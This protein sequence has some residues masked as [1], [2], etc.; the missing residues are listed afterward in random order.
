MNASIRGIEY[1]LPEQA[2]SNRDLA[3]EFPE[4]TIG[5]IQGKTGI[6]ERHVAAPNETAADLAAQAARKL[7]D[8]GACSTNEI[9][10][11]LLCTQTP[12]HFLPTTACLLQHRLGIPT[13]AGALDFNLGC[14]GFVYG[15]G[16]AQ[17]LIETE[18]ATCI[19]LLTAETYTKLIHPRDRS[20]RTLFGDAAAA[21]LITATPAPERRRSS[22]T[23][24]TDGSGGPNL[25]VPAGGMR[26][27][28]S[29][30][31]AQAVEDDT[32]N[33][34]SP[35][36]LYMDGAEIF[37]FT[38][39]AIPECV[40][41]VLARG[42]KQLDDIDLFV[43]HQANQYMLDHLRK[44]LGIPAAKFYVHLENCGNTISSTIPIALKHA[45]GAKRL[46]A[47]QTV[48]LVGFGVGYSWA[49]TILEWPLLGLSET[50][51]AK[52]KVPEL[53]ATSSERS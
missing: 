37:N 18:Q 34:R 6:L 49:A 41:R 19:L 10:F 53:T 12:D 52:E 51:G 39:S 30:E 27:R 38:L 14:S 45:L 36:N 24:G 47:G 11:L 44:K 1:H 16:L 3:A 29:A 48:M 31:T 15:L 21:T 42:R 26:R 25:I 13:H 33:W 8:S 40:N 28:S 46:E 7:F 35:D 20:V 2:V 4:W 22:Y 5:K 17:G 43:F 23:W 32:G 50:R 9:D